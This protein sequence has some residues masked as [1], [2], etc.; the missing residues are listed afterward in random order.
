MAYLY[1]HAK[2]GHPSV[3]ITD[4]KPDPTLADLDRTGEGSL[5]A[6]PPDC[7]SG[8]AGHL[9]YFFYTNNTFEHLYELLK[10]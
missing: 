5:P 8:Q 6:F 9:H 10:L 1:R 4:A 7:R 3:K 2:T